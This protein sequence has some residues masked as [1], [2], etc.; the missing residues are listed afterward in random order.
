MKR[1]AFLLM[2]GALVC[3]GLTL[4]SYA[5]VPKCKAASHLAVVAPASKPL[6]ASAVSVQRITNGSCRNDLGYTGALYVLTI[7]GRPGLQLLPDGAAYVLHAF[8]ATSGAV[9]LDHTVNK[10]YRPYKTFDDGARTEIV[11]ELQA[12]G[13]S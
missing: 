6:A 5:Q 7:K 12:E 11:T 3:Y 8:A 13:V 1:L 9:T 10:V 2:I 4:H